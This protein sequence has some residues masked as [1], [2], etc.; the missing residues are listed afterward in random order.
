MSKNNR[1]ISPVLATLLLIVITVACITVSYVL[2]MTY[3]KILTPM[4]TAA[5]EN[6][7]Q[8][9]N[10]GMIILNDGRLDTFYFHGFTHSTYNGD[11]LVIGHRVWSQNLNA[12]VMSDMSISAATDFWLLNHHYK[13][14]DYNP[15]TC[16]IWLKELEG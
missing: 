11:Y 6:N 4:V 16:Q 10:G 3:Y 5:S 12:A 2:V 15:V 14:T 1:G 8:L 13:I 7:G 9:Y